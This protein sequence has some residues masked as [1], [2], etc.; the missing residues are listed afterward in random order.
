[1]PRRDPFAPVL[2]NRFAAFLR[3]EAARG[4]APNAVPVA[5]A[6]AP[7][8][9]FADGRERVN[10]GS[11]NYLGL[12][13]DPRVVSAAREALDRYGTGSS[14]S[15]ILNGTTRL[16]LDLEQ[17][18]AD[19]YGVEAAVVTPSGFTANLALL[20]SIGAPGDALLVDA[21]S[22]ASLRAGADASR[23]AVVRWRHND[24]ASLRERL[25]RLDPDAGAVVVVDG[26]YSMHGEVAPLVE[27]L[28]LCREHG[29]RLVVDEAHGIGVLGA[30]GRGAAEAA[31][32][33]D[34]VDAVTVTMSK[35]LG[36]CGGA[37][38]TSAAVA[39]GLR[40]AA[41]PYVFAASNVPASVGAALAALRVLR[42]E[43]E[44][45]ARVRQ[46]GALLRSL[47]RQ[48]GVRALP[49]D[50][51]IIAVPVG[52]G[53]DTVAAWRRVFDAGVYANAATFPAVPQGEGIL[54]L[55]VMATHTEEQL[56]RGVAAI[57]AVLDTPSEPMPAEP[58]GSV[59]TLP[60]TADVAAPR[61]PAQRSAAVPAWSR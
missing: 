10:L 22:H 33:L 37:V 14:G 54:R 16:H 58:E 45:S 53:G 34:E 39:E 60:S 1:M 5:G 27:V 40:S 43:P 55:S 49:G 52:D 59:I 25:T 4:T 56:A 38:L 17:E 32:V 24:L 47:L 19:Y 42:A 50:G 51:P 31:G 9:L 44:R 30:L 28:A 61:P 8:T 36:S 13:T 57:A 46:R 18:L 21:H 29:A 35:S 48:A 15:R 12:T 3:V 20:G 6:A 41:V 23:A 2:R 7:V 26:V 11:N